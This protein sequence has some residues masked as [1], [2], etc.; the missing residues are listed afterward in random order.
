MKWIFAAV[1]A[2]AAL[3]AVLVPS[4]KMGTGPGGGVTMILV[5]APVLLPQ[6]V[7]AGVAIAFAFG[8]AIVAS[9]QR[10]AA[11]Q[12]VAMGPHLAQTETGRQG[13]S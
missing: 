7:A 8:T 12:M 11:R 6:A 10:P 5:F 13:S 1:T 2:L 3:A 4:F 9:P